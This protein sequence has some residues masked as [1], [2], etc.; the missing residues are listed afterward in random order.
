MGSD[1]RP[2]RAQSESAATPSAAVRVGDPS[3]ADLATVAGSY[4]LHV[5]PEKAR[6][7]PTPGSNPHDENRLNDAEPP[8]PL[9]P[10]GQNMS[11]APLLVRSSPAQGTGSYGGL[12]IMSLSSSPGSDTDH[13][14]VTNLLQRNTRK[15]KSRLR[16]SEPAASHSRTSLHRYRDDSVQSEPIRTSRSRRRSVKEGSSSRA[17]DETFGEEVDSGLEPRFNASSA[18]PTGAGVS[19]I[20][21]SLHSSSSSSRLEEED[22]EESSESDDLHDLKTNG[23]QPSDN[24]PYAQVRAS[25]A[26]TDDT[27][28]SINTPRMWIL[29]I[30]F[31]ILGSSTN[32]FFSLRYPSVSITPII[33]LLLVHPLGLLWDQ[34]LK[35]A[36]DPVETF[37]HGAAQPNGDHSTT[38]THANGSRPGSAHA[39]PSLPLKRSWKG[40]SR[41]WLAQ[42]RWNEKEHCCVYISSNVSFGFA[43]ATDVIVEQTKFYHQDLG[44]TYQ[45]LLTLSTQILGYALAGLTRQYLVRPSGMIWPATLV[46]TAMF[47]AL[48]KDQNKPADGWTVSRSRFFVLVLCGSFAFYF[49]PGLLMPAL[50]YFSVITW[51]APNNVVVANL[52]GIASGLGLF[53]LTFDWAQI[54]Y[55]GSPLVTPF[56]AA[57]NIIGGLVLVMWIAAPLMYYAN[58][59]Y[60][61]Y[62]PI[63][64]SAVFD[65]KGKP[66]DV[67][68]ILTDNF[69]FDEEAYQKYSRVFLP[70]TYVLSYALQFAALTAL[71]SHTALWHGKDIMKQWRRSWAEIR[72][73][74]ETGY[75]PLPGSADGNGTSAP[76]RTGTRSSTTSEPELEDLLTSEDVHNRL[77][78]QYDDVPILWYIL[79]GV[80]M[81]AIG[82]FVVE[83]Y[84]IHLPWYGLLLALSIGAVL[85]IPIGIVMAITNQQSSLYLICQ[86]ICGVAFPGRPVANMVF[87]TYGYITSTQGLKFSSDL[88]LGH[89]M[90]IPPKILFNLQL[91]ATIISSLTQIGVLNWMLAFIP[92]ICTPQ[93]INGFTCPIARV[94]FNGSILWGVVGPRRFFGPDALYRPLVWAFLVGAVAPIVLWYLARNHRKSILRKVNLAVVFGSLS[95]IPPATGLNFSVWG[96]V[97]YVFNY[98]IRRRKTAWW[99]KYNMTLSAALDSGLAVGLV[100]IFFGIVF[101]GWMDGFKWWGTE[102]YKQ[103][104]DWRACSYKTAPD[105]DR[106]GPH[107]W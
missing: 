13:D 89:Y 52:F 66:Y 99:K 69:V 38:S 45:I 8:A 76:S 5:L 47:S 4:E 32:L 51:F 100:V 65:N 41:L 102:V 59:M 88:K 62:M 74:Q 95:W 61:A 7:N 36:D 9:S 1:A 27:S 31:A 40:R 26:A 24:S 106:F 93:A 81:T 44:V 98:E 79:T 15:G 101:P 22:D 35:R 28:L 78:R 107:K 21:E 72:K 39:L 17:L 18:A 82:I 96:I 56:W 2:S 33:A 97:C 57:L 94:H 64:S 25:V 46:S 48:H 49:L 91:S 19:S 29:S 43:F 71:I 12:P 103:G 68:K 16:D 87:T 90:K 58:V 105:G 54:A 83:Y 60:S 63:L 73:K 85:F 67:S 84:P 11:R 37:V 53:P 104:C 80:S 70:I 77:M 50:S 30:L 10:S 75:E 34:V 6:S 92:G 14:H 3:G 23:H 55:I 42:G 20:F 86:L